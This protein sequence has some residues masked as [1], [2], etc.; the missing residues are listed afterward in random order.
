MDKVLKYKYKTEFAIMTELV[1]A[2]DPCGLIEMGAPSDEYDGL[3]EKLLSCV[4][5][6]MIIPEIKEYVLHEIQCYFEYPDLT[7]FV[8]PYKTHFYNNLDK[9]LKETET[10][11]Y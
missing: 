10:M 5:N 4:Y 11:F 6:K 8:Q 9:L 3:T 7:I 1:N 2:F